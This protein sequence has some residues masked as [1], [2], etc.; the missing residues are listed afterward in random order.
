MTGLNPSH[1]SRNGAGKDAV[2]DIPD[3]DL[4]RFPVE[5]VSW[6]DCQVFLKRLN[7]QAKDTGWVYRLPREAEWEYACRSG[8]V[9]KFDSAFAFYFAKPTNTLLPVQAN[10]APEPGKGLQR[11]C[12][13]GSYEPNAIGLYDMHGNVCE[14]CD[15]TEN[16]ADAASDRVIRGGVWRNDSANC[17]A[18]LYGFQRLSYLS[19]YLGL[20][21]ARV[22]VGTTVPTS[23]TTADTER[24]LAEWLIK[25]PGVE[26]IR[27]IRED[28]SL[29]PEVKTGD[30]LP[31]G[32]F[33]VT[34]LH[35]LEADA[36]TDADLARI[37]QAHRLGVLS[38]GSIAGKLPNVTDKGLDRLFSSAVSKSLGQLQISEA[39]LPNV[40]DDG[41]P[42]LNRA[43]N[44]G[45]L[46]LYPLQ[47]GRG[48]F[49]SQLD[50]PKLGEFRVL[51]E[52]IPGGWLVPFSKRSPDLPFIMVKGSRLTRADVQALAEMDLIRGLDLS[53][54]GLDDESLM[55]L[56]KMSK[57]NELA[58]NES[59]EITDVGAAKLAS[60]KEIKSISLGDCS[61]GDETCKTLATLDKL[62]YAFLAHT[63]VSDRGVEALA[64][65]KALKH[66]VLSDTRL[67]DKGVELLAPLN[68][69]ETL[70]LSQ[71]KR[72]TD[73]G[74]ESLAKIGSLTYLEIQTNPQ[75][76][77]AAV[78]KLQAALPKCKIVSDFGTLEPTKD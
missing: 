27:L 40:T 64:L 2:K 3:A 65:L 34:L 50:L 4:K 51:G 36:I 42:V 26:L 15:L 74:L 32:A 49:L 31:D 72:L 52:G 14:W 58:L 44:L 77:E 25:Q 21:L 63:R 7:E 35:W 20:R 1:F 47:A 66:L 9:D 10:F 19:D 60:L 13:V 8:P 16:A 39:R 23:T 70:Q 37:G 73:Q 61:I 45:L 17:R 71:C 38:L 29:L 48:A 76:T 56:S 30:K 33:F 5:N 46:N 22:R 57:V 28:G 12:K 69:L 59:P 6:D 41:Y 54:C 67:T 62:E 18:A 55:L 43:R 24:D 68:S 53:N 11:T 78:R 75:L